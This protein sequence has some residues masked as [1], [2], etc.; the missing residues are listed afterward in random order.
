[1]LDLVNMVNV[2]RVFTAGDGKAAKPGQ[3]SCSRSVS[4]V[5]TVVGAGMLCAVG[6][7]V[8]VVTFTVAVNETLQPTVNV[9]VWH[10]RPT[11]QDV[12]VPDEPGSVG[13]LVVSGAG[14]LPG[15]VSR[16][17]FGGGGEVAGATVVA[18]DGTQTSTI[19][20]PDHVQ[21]TGSPLI[22]GQSAT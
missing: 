1:M 17:R 4:E 16:V 8:P 7:C 14:H 9:I 2:E 11:M 15:G 18:A 21:G 13:A 10:E 5:A 22:D 20:V 19:R 12:G 3:G 6:A